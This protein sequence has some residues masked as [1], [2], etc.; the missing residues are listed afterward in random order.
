MTN[1]TQR[2]GLAAGAALIT[3]GMAAGVFAF[4]QNQT[5]TPPPRPFGQRMGPRG[6]IMGM[7]FGL[8]GLAGPMAERLGL[9]DAQK[10]Q[11][12]AIAAAHRDEFKALAD[13]ASAAH[14]ALL[15]AIMLD[16]VND[17]AVQQAS[18]GV[19]AV[20]SDMAVA[21]AHVRAEMFQVL[22]DDQKATVKQM[23]ANRPQ[24]HGRGHR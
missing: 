19:A 2:I 17:A 24:M 1:R 13:R 18:A 3:I 12:K 7:P 14:D 20:Q 8:M 16:P 22:T 5:T 6:G 10:D 4:A 11:L 15:Q 21:G 23:I 9:S